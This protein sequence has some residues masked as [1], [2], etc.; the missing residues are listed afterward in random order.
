MGGVLMSL[1]GVAGPDR[2]I[3]EGALEWQD[4]G[5]P[6]LPSTDE[7]LMEYGLESSYDGG[8]TS[9]SEISAKFAGLCVRSGNGTSSAKRSERWTW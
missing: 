4:D 9:Y 3:E 6:L 8:L 7:L 2:E 5:E 1:V